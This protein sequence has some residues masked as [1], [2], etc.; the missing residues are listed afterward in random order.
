MIEPR[1]ISPITIVFNQLSLVTIPDKASDVR[2]KTKKIID[3]ENLIS[4]IRKKERLGYELLYDSY[5]A[6][7]FGVINKIIP[8][9]EVAEDLLSEAFVKIINSFAQYDA[10]RGRLFTWMINICRNLCFDELRSKQ[11]KNQTRSMKLDDCTE[12]LCDH[13]TSFNPSHSDLKNITERLNPNQKL[14]IDLA[15][16]KGY[17]HSEIAKEFNLPLGTVKTRLRKAINELRL[18][19]QF[20]A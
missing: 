6:V 10:S 20:S 17:T 1:N 9:T 18:I 4:S 19:Y 8:E 5:S 15:F 14:L 11:F 3:E 16:F 2:E 7:L 12:L 13:T